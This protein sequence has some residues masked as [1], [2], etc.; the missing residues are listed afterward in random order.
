[1]SLKEVLAKK[2]EAH[3]PRTTRLVK[4]YGDVK[5][6]EVTISQVIGGM[7]GIKSLVTDISYLDPMEGIR[8]R[9]MTIP[10]TFAALPKVPG[11]E[12]PYVEGFW[13]L[14][15]TGDVP[16]MEQTL[17][18]VAD[19]KAR[20]QVPEYVWDILRT[21]P[22]DTHPMTMFSAAILAMQRES[23]FA[24]NYAAG[25]FNK[26][27]CWEDMYEDCNNL[28]AKLPTIAA[29]IYRM[30]YKGDTPIAPNPELDWGGNFAHMMGI[31][32]PYDD[33]A[34]MYFILHSDHESGNVSAHTTHL[35]ASALSDAYYS[36]SA[37]I[38][39]LAGP[40][41]GLANQEVLA[42]TQNFMQKLGGKLPTKEELEKALWDTL[43]SG[44]VIPG[45]GHAV[46]RKTDPRYTS[47]REFC[48]KTPGLKDY[49]LFQLVSMIYEVAPKVLMEHGKAK[50]PWPNVDAQ[51]GVIQW[52]YGVT[53]YDFYTVLFG[54]GRALGVLANITWDRALGY[55]IERPK[56]VTTDML[57]EIAGIKK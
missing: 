15:L 39:G 23:I 5:V 4:E 28:L 20:S 46:L 36:L 10:E 30:K 51:S 40:L 19:W 50:N 54:V 21:M 38:N 52:Y 27:T 48:L 49:P 2:I 45:Y 31:G 56:S 16:T 37:G 18:V 57:E 11:S 34:R 32:K 53:E 9:G 7:R 42:W 1:M 55:P 41:H 6:G 17:E 35:V 33:V 44:Q 43:N 29:Y 8:F 13:W 24:K 26:M 22:R 12:Y 25:K 3:R 47:Q 14:L